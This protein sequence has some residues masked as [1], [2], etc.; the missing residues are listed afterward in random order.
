MTPV[1]ICFVIPP[2]PKQKFKR[3]V[4]LFYVGLTVKALIGFNK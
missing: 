3:Q 1:T 4:A 2:K